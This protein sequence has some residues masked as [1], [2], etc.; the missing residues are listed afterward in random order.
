MF[1]HPRPELRGTPADFGADFETVAMARPDGGTTHGWWVPLDGAEAVVVVFGGNSGN[2]SHHLA[3]ARILREAGFS[4]LMPDYQ[5]FGPEGGAPSLSSFEPDAAAAVRFA[6][7]KS[8][9]VGVWGV[10]LGSAVALGV[11]ARRP[12]C[13]RAVC[14]E[15]SFRLRPA[16]RQYV[17]FS[18]GRALAPPLAALTRAFFLDAASDP[19]RTVARRA[20][21]V[22]VLFVH[23]DRDRLTRTLWAAELFAL[24]PGPKEFWLMPDTGHAPEPLRSADGEY[25]QQVAR[26]FRRT[27]LGEPQPQAGATWSSWP[28]DGGW[29]TRVRVVAGPPFPAPV[30]VSVVAD[31]EVARARLWMTRGQDEVVL[32]T[33]GRPAAAT[34][35]RI[36]RVA[37]HPS[38]WSP[39]LTPV[40]RGHA[41]LRRLALEV[42][43]GRGPEEALLA[44]RPDPVLAPAAA[45]LLFLAG[46]AATDAGAQRRL[47]LK[48]LDLAPETPG[49]F[50]LGDATYFEPEEW[51]REAI[52]RRILAWTARLGLDPAEF[53]ATMERR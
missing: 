20:E 42:D 11:A 5:G 14:V 18:V 52:R 15:G 32:E 53:E 31:G 34:A 9:R 1:L 51:T 13:V 30:E 38:A 12:E 37:C 10:S 41:E 21:N 29:A 16:L 22:P 6:E 35:R 47:L 3:H 4:V 28:Q 2:R 19:E 23:G 33:A 36:V 44:L 8:P 17:G 46:L 43:A 45:R 39:D 27:L 7:T 26:F 25:A 24:A 50:I 48:S 40:A 49:H